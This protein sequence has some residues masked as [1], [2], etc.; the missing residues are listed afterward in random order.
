MKPIISDRVE[1]QSHRPHPELP[2]GGADPLRMK[3]VLCCTA[4]GT[5]VGILLGA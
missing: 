4:A 3:P 1:F 5:E 2:T